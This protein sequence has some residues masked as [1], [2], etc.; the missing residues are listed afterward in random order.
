MKK[1]KEFGADAALQVH[2]S[3]ESPTVTVDSSAINGGNNMEII[4][5]DAHIMALADRSA[6][7][8]CAN[9]RPWG[10]DVDDV[11]SR[12]WECYA[13]VEP[14]I[15]CHPKDSPEREA[16]ARTVI[17]VALNHCKDESKANRAR[18]QPFQV[19][20]AYERGENPDRAAV[21]LGEDIADF[22]R[23]GNSAAQRR[24][25]L[26]IALRHMEPRD[27]A[28]CRAYLELVSWE[29]VA[30]R[31]GYSEGDFRRKVMPGLKERAQAV[32]RK[33]W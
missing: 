30:K 11:R 5:E 2:T 12:I 8:F 24:H 28:I 3:L 27:A 32:W 20:K 31:F 9:Y 18:M 16:A 23:R 1:L 4:R 22:Y 13:K 21:A 29:A 19:R 7:A 26:H 17:A 25:Y 6:R 33:I 14:Q 15:V 10:M